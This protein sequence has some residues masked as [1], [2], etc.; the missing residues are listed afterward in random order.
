MIRTLVSVSPDL[1]SVIAVNYACHLSKSIPMNIQPVFVKE[2]EPERDVP[3][4]GWVRR[5]W[6]DSLL[7]IEHEAVSRL[8]EAERGNC[9]ALIKPMI[10][11]GKWE[12][13]ILS[14]L[15]EGSFDLFVEG[16]VASFEK[17]EIIRQFNS[18]LYRNVPCPVIIAR[19]LIKLHKVLLVFNHESGIGKVVPAM[20]SLFRGTKMHFDVMY[21]NILDRGRPVELIE[22]SDSLFREA[23]AILESAG[24][25]PEKRIA[26]QGGAEN[27]AR[28]IEEYSL[29]AISLPSDQTIDDRFFEM[30]G[31]VSSPILLCRRRPKRSSA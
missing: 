7:S 16:S 14:C 1:A 27:L 22:A 19:N 11:M 12:D 20:S 4:V 28:Q 29:I 17:S 8:I 21:V 24:L 2:P 23:N 13:M 30:L 18:P 25:T 5:T 6:E 9:P 15:L 26:L 31:D 3:G 10:L